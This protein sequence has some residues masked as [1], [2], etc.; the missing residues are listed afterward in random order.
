VVQ[1]FSII[2]LVKLCFRRIH[3]LDWKTESEP[4]PLIP[5]TVLVGWRHGADILISDPFVFQVL[6]KTPTQS[7]FPVRPQ[8]KLELP[9][10]Y[11]NRR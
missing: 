4:E 8:V 5:V 1:L 10:L 3:L 11:L 2:V 6:K 9:E 7:P